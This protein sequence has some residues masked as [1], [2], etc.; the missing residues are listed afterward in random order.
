MCQSVHARSSTC[1]LGNGPDRR[2]NFQFAGS[3]AAR[4]VGWIFRESE[5]E[6]PGE[7][8]KQQRQASE[9]RKKAQ[10]PDTWDPPGS[11]SKKTQ[12]S[13]DN[14]GSVEEEEVRK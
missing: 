14:E 1:S 13:K 7:Q 2:D 10:G 4:R 6:R 8:N 9:E 5:R 11:A 12:K 3:P